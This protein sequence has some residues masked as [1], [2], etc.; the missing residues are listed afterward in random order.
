MDQSEYERI[1]S[2]LFQVFGN[3]INQADYGSSAAEAEFA[4][5]AAQAALALIELDRNHEGKVPGNVK[6]V[7]EA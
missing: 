3:A 7:L 2:G 4:K 1:K 5:A 6:P